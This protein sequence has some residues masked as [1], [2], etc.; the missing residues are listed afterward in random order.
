ME[1][2]NVYYLGGLIFH[3]QIHQRYLN[4]Y[5][6]YKIKIYKLWDACPRVVDP[7]Q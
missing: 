6:S 4:Y 2:M 5:L 7:R 3:S 1:V